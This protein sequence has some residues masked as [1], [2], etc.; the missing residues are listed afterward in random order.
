MAKKT[1]KIPKWI[2][3]IKIPK[4]VRK[5][6]LR[7]LLGTPAGQI[8]LAE[9]LIVI[10]GAIATAANPDTKT[11]R[12]LRMAM[13][14]GLAGLKGGDTGKG[15]KRHIASHL[16]DGLVRGLEAFRQSM[17]ATAV[18]PE[19]K[20]VQPLGRGKKKSSKSQASPEPTTH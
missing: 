13:N 10:G 7:T 11:G 5:G 4:Q 15:S 8:L 3:G 2:A 19:M 6:P 18:A 12:A 17:R 9:L 16:G 1:S 14:E 20:D